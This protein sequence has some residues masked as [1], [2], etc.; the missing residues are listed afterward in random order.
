MT[1]EG[2][3]PAEDTAALAKSLLELPSGSGAYRWLYADATS[4]D[5]TAVVIFMLGSPFS[6]RYSAGLG[7][8]ARPLEHCAVNFA[9][10]AGG[11]RRTWVL[12][13][14]AGAQVDSGHTLRIGGSSWRY[15]GDGSVEVR[16]DELAARGRERVQ[17]VLQL[18]PRSPPHAPVQLVP[19]E[20]HHW[21]PVAARAEAHLEVPTHALEA[22]AAH[23]YHDANFGSER[24]GL[25]VPRWRWTRVHGAEETTVLYEPEGAPALRVRATGEAVAIERA[26]T[27]HGEPAGARRA[28]GAPA[29]TSPATAGAT[30]WTRWALRI[31]TALHGS[32]DGRARLLES[33]PF[34]A[35][36]EARSGAVHALAEVADFARFHHP[37]IR[38]MASWRTRYA[39]RPAGRRALATTAERRLPAGT[40]ERAVGPAEAGV[41]LDAGAPR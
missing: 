31:P 19:G 33:S 24:L 21:Q 25:G 36:L 1:L 16:V 28:G 6:A 26:A 35:R 23:G 22:P 20:P 5:V 18:R 27:A 8:G 2:L 10:Y 32:P 11:L 15:R 3:T 17:A 41:E 9:L 29:P 34:Y 38:W 7:R 12:T 37:A 14:H 40:T 30:R 4:G 13:E 39:Q